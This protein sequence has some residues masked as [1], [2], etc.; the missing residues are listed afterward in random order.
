MVTFEKLRGVV[1][2]KA[3]VIGMETFRNLSKQHDAFWDEMNE[4]EFQRG[5]VQEEYEKSDTP[6]L[7][8]MKLLA[9]EEFDQLVEKFVI[10]HAKWLAKN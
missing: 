10:I 4:V 5:Y 7:F 2:K 8:E 1:M 3:G 9:E 6:A